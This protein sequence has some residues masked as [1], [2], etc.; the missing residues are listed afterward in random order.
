MKKFKLTV[1]SILSVLFLSACIKNEEPNSE[2]DIISCEIVENGVNNE[3]LILKTAPIVNNN[4]KGNFTIRLL[5]KDGK[6]VGSMT[7][8]FDV[9]EGATVF[10]ESFMGNYN[11][12]P[13]E[14]IALDFSSS[15]RVKVVSEDKKWSKIYT[16]SVIKSE[17]PL[18]LPFENVE[19]Q[20]PSKTNSYY[21]FVEVNDKQ[22]ITMTWASGNPGFS[23]TG[24]KKNPEHFPTSQDPNGYKGNCLKMVTQSTGTFGKL[25]D[26]PIAA[27]NL[28]TGQF[29]TSESLSNPLNATKFGSPF[30]QIPTH[31]NGYYK[32]KKGLIFTEVHDKNPNRQDMGDIYAVFY[33]TDKDFNTLTGNNQFTD[34]HIVSIARIG[35]QSE[36]MKE[37]E[38]WIEFNLT[39]IQKEGKY[40][41]LKKLEEGYYKL[42]IVFS[43]SIDG[44]KF[45]GAVGSTLFI[46]EVNIIVKD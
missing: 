16:I 23:L 10:L 29:E 1:L 2:A 21:D 24:S 9:T 11:P 15:K 44:D 14:G 7:P 38:E 46:D 22:Q 4:A 32:Y 31:I 42:A 18:Y 37:T 27:G 35:Q 39:F 12:Y 19:I 13:S 20:H 8:I 34:E 5:V 17:I 28:F 45:H 41:D 3:N 40:V 43:S 33:E 30:S 36:A 6:D 25:A 26:K